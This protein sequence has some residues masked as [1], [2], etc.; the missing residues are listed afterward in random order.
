MPWNLLILP[1]AAGY[2]LITRSN[3]FKYFQQRLDR[4][5]LIFDTILLGIAISII[6]FLVRL[7]FDY[8]L[9][10][11]IDSIYKFLPLRVS[12]FGTTLATFFGTVCFVEVTNKFVFSNRNKQIKRAIEL[13]GNELEKIFAD[14]FFNDELLEFTL[15]TNKVYIGQVRELPIP[16]TT[17][18]IR[19]IP[20]VSG[21]RNSKKKLIFTTKYYTVYN[22]YILEGTISQIDELNV[23]LIITLDNLVSVSYFDHQTYKMFNPVKEEK[24][25]ESY[26][27]EPK[28]SEY[29]VNYIVAQE[30]LEIKNTVPSKG[31]S[32]IT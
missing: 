30:E 1:L 2:Y 11:L 6:G 20:W 18:F 9:P 29:E 21:Y 12:F 24:T 5:R 4:Q 10:N 13:H 31:D 17:N 23:D 27:E 15:D 7:L 28:D 19:I 32:S 26:D 22:Q 3:Y 25:E 14:S 8:T 16:T